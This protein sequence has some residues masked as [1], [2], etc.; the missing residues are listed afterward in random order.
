MITTFVEVT[1]GERN[2][3]KFMVGRFDGADWLYKS[4]VDV[5]EGCCADGGSLLAGRG[6]SPRHLF[7]MDLQTGEGAMF[8]PGGSAKADLNKHKIWVCPLFEP[9]LEWLYQQN[10]SLHDLPAHVD[11][12]DAPFAWQGYR[13]A[14]E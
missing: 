7:V 12:P 10:L 4:K 14:G 6:W 9:F 5:H 2:W 13:R 11:L 1:N 8:S 3:G